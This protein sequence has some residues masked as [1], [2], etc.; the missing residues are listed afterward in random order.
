METK[1]LTCMTGA[2]GSLSDLD[3]KIIS[4]L[5]TEL[6]GLFPAWRQAFGTQRE[7]RNVQKVWAKALISC[8]LTDWGHIQ[9]GLNK[10]KQSHN[11]FFPSVGAFISWCVPVSKIR[12]DVWCQGSL[13]EEMRQHY[14][15]Q[16]GVYC[17]DGQ[18]YFGQSPSQEALNK[19]LSAS[20]FSFE[21]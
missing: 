17:E 19:A 12:I 5:L 13:R 9:R 16:F 8:N 7:I 21:R 1:N 2:M 6:Q 14:L 11:P 4:D 10:A 18:Y 15:S 3:K 20:L